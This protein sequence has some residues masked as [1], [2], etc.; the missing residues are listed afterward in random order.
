MFLFFL[1]LLLPLL[2]LSS[3]LGYVCMHLLIITSMGWLGKW[4]TKRT[5]ARQMIEI[6]EK[7]RKPPLRTPHSVSFENP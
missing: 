7:K 4:K 6:A 5:K 2:Q 3:M 1:L